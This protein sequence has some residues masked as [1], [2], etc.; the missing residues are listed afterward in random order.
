MGMFRA[1]IL[2]ALA[3]H[4]RETERLLD[5]SRREH[6]EAR[7]A[8][9]RLL[10]R[11]EQALEDDRRAG[12]HLEA[13]FASGVQALQ[14][15]VLDLASRVSHLEQA[16]A[17]APSQANGAGP[18]GAGPDVAGQLRDVSAQLEALRRRIPLR[19]R[20]EVPGLDEATVEAIAAAVEAR[21]RTRPAGARR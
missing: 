15:A 9:D 16:V 3:D 5:R 8:G 10:E 21:L 18:D 11:V 1:Q 20:Q 13:T 17:S 6:A 12:E 19:G 7:A 14:R 4:R 2:E